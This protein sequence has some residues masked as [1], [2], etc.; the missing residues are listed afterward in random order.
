MDRWMPQNIS[1]DKSTLVC[2]INLANVD[3]DLCRHMASQGLNELSYTLHQHKAKFHS[4][5][6]GSAAVCAFTYTCCH[7]SIHIHPTGSAA[8]YAFTYT[9]VVWLPSMHLHTP[10]WFG[11]HLCIYIYIHPTGS[12]VIYAFT[13]TQLVRLPSMH[14]HTPNWCACHLCIYIH[15][16]GS[17]AICAFKYTKFVAVVPSRSR[18]TDQTWLGTTILVPYFLIESTQLFKRVR[19][20]YCCPVFKWV[21]DS[22]SCDR[23]PG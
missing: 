5:T 13:Y 7:L 14:L 18:V 15:Q 9:Q 23:V 8:I 20:I 17:P 6:T 19:F 3:Q 1:D 21:A 4:S 12:A 10:N 22:W 11:C 2:V 16:T